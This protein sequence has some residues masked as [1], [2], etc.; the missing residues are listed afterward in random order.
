MIHNEL[1]GSGHPPAS[2][3]GMV[4]HSV[5]DGTKIGQ[6]DPVNR[7]VDTFYAQLRNPDA[8]SKKK[9]L[10]RLMPTHGIVNVIWIFDRSIVCL[11][12]L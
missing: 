3:R 12:G 6:G 11:S 9:I 7:D 2:I 8:N 10:M 4:H 5:L 1:D